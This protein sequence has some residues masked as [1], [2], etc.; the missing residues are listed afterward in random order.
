M[1]ALEVEFFDLLTTSEARWTTLLIE[2]RTWINFDIQR[3]AWQTE[4]DRLKTG[5]IAIATFRRADANET[6]A[7]ESDAASAPVD[8]EE[9][10]SLWVTPESR[11]A[12]FEVGDRRVDVVIEGSTFWSNGLGRSFTNGGSKNHSHGQGDG[13]NLIRTQ[14]YSRLLQIVELA[15]GTQIER[16]T[17]DAKVIISKSED[18]DL[19]PVLHGLT[20]GDADFLELRV[21]RERGVVLS[22]SSWFQGVIYRIVEVT[23]VEFDLNFDKNAFRIE[24]EF[25][26]EWASSL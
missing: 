23:K 24:P 26:T 22:A 5:G 18:P 12:K 16:Q 6:E 7:P 10:W 8:H 1:S 13:R 2:G 15:E 19:G 9:T 25:D 4:I 20:I 21:D 11:R 3:V 17:I 14:E